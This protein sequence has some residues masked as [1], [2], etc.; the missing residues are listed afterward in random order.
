MTA[1]NFSRRIARIPTRFYEARKVFF[2][3]PGLFYRWRLYQVYRRIA[4]GWLDNFAL[5]IE[6]VCSARDNQSIPRVADAGKILNGLLVMHN[7]IRIR[8]GSYVDERMTEM[9][10][11]NGAVHEPQEEAAFGIVLSWLRETGSDN[12]TMVELGAFWA[13]YSLWFKTALPSANCFCVEPDATNLSWGQQNFDLNRQI[14]DFT[15]AYVGSAPKAGDPP[16]ISVDSFVR[17]KQIEHIHIL[18][19]DIQGYELEM[20]HGAEQTF[21]RRMID[22]V[23]ISTHR[24]GL[25][26]RCLEQLDK[27]DFRILADADLLESHSLDGLIVAARKEMDCPERVPIHHR[28][29]K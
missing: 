7:G 5:R 8:P 1:S 12:Y 18:H 21:R 4:H 15:R 24:H 25:H 29:P 11:E 23:F 3:R 13:F 10:K 22:Y 28:T 17:A 26:Y 14:A 20:L 19:C 16:T 9:L 2:K 27:F 6:D